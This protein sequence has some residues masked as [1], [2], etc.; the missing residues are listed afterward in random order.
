MRNKVA[1][2]PE[3][4]F[5]DYFELNRNLLDYIEQVKIAKPAYLF[6]SESIQEDP[7]IKDI[8]GQYFGKVYSAME[9]GM[10][11]KDPETYKFIARDLKLDVS[12]IL[13]IDDSLSNVEAAI[14]AGMP[15][16]Q[17]K[18]NNVVGLIEGRINS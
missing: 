3:F 8:L 12:D 9:L 17:Y 15:A 16:I 18:D 1:G 14:N 5:L 6:T 7:A 13:F 11:K 2:T 4:K 10:S